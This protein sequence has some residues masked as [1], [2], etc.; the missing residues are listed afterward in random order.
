MQRQLAAILFAD[1]AGYSRL[2]DA[3]ESEIHPRMMALLEEVVEVAIASEAGRI[4]KSTGD[5]CLACFASVNSAVQAAVRIQQEVHQRE[6]SQ[7]PE[8][9]IAFAWGCI[10]ATS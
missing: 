6:A 3:Y 7:P 10:R 8:K 5:G 4:V 9:Q 2:M 1:V